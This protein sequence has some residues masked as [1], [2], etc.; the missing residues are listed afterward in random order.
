MNRYL[1]LSF[2]VLVSYHIAYS[3]ISTQNDIIDSLVTN[4]MYRNHIPGLSLAII[5]N[6]EVIKKNFYGFSNIDSKTVVNQNTTFEIASMSKQITCT[7]ILLLEEEGKL[8][9]TDKLAKYIDSI[10]ETWT[11]ITL[12]Q[13]MNHTSGLRDDWDEPTS[14][15]LDNYTDAKMAKAQ[16]DFPLCFEPGKGFY[17]S[18]GPFFLGLVI[19]SITGKHYS[20]FLNERIFKPLQMN[21]TSVYSEDRINELAH[22]YKWNN[23]SY[24]AGVDIP[25]SAESRADVGV[26][27]SLDDMI[28]WDMALTDNRLLSPESLAKM[29]KAGKLSNGARIPYGYGWYIYSFRNKLMFEHG[30]AFRTGYNSRITRFPEDK[31]EII[32]LCNKWQASLSDLTY[33]IAT[34]YISDF[35]NISSLISMPDEQKEKTLQYESLFRDMSNKKLSNAE[36]YKHVNI[37]GFDSNELEELLIG[38]K[39]LEFIDEISFDTNQ[40]ILYESPIVKTMY[41]KAIA[42]K[43]TYWSLTFSESNKL[44][45]INLED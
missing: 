25:P 38:F 19:E 21:S 27:A 45:S 36:L 3:K 22:G 40:K 9:L 5:K 18:S 11:D 24:L 17:Y 12:E 16:K 32:I 41:Y 7:A 28:K 42:E 15:F 2:I 33:E 20:Y 26:V 34:N 1:F 8:K 39:R 35:K 44:I 30:G 13:L 6:N 10:P 31:L 14:Y 43:T 37:S 29:F 4:H 23:G